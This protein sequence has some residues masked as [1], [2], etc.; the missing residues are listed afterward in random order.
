MTIAGVLNLLAWVL[1]AV[2]AAWLIF[3]MLR[4]ARQHDERQLTTVAEIDLPLEAP[5]QS[6]GTR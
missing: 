6:G 2:I 1:S 5:D 4:V 3:D